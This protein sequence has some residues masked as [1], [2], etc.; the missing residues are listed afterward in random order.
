MIED[1]VAAAP[2]GLAAATAM[3][4]VAP[5]GSRSMRRSDIV[6]G[7]LVSRLGGFFDG[8]FASSD[9]RALASLWSMYYFGGL[10]VPVTVAMLRLD[11]ALPVALETLAFDLDPIGR[12]ERFYLPHGGVK[13]QSGARFDT[14]VHEHLSLLIA[15]VAKHSGLSPRV[16][17]SNAAVILDYVVNEVVV[18]GGA[19]PE[20]LAEARSLLA[21]SGSPCFGI[22]R[23]F[24]EAPT[25]GQRE[26]TV[27]CLRYKLPGVGACPGICP[28][29]R[30]LQR[31]PCP[32]YLAIAEA[33]SLHAGPV[34]V[35]G[36]S[37]AL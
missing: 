34:Q 4:T 20:A 24:V 5:P 11:R 28:L 27:C 8:T 2:R 9:R 23:P 22:T 13:G 14:L 17:W 32:G 25:N 7:A 29:E 3:M 35:E 1:L 10:I 19:H 37:S 18:D 30:R 15:S 16:L 31:A 12:V 33:G 36:R 6:S 26:R 21:G